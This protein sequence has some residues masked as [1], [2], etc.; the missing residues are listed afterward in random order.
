MAGCC[1]DE[2]EIAS[3]ALQKRQRRMLWAVLC[4]NA[5]MFAVEFGAGVLAGSTALLGDSL[6]MLGDAMVYALSL[7]VIAKSLRWKAMSA[8]IKGAVMLVFSVLVLL[9]AIHKAVAGAV[10]ASA[11]MMVIGSAALLANMAC[12]LLLTRHRED[13]VNM[14][15]AWV[16]SRNDLVANTGV[17]VAGIAVHVTQ[18]VWPDILV[19]GAI[20]V[21]F[22]QSSIGVLRDAWLRYRDSSR[23]GGFSDSNAGQSLR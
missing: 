21:L 3:R 1:C 11:L 10:P 17:I 12:L 14:R 2:N 20:A 6:D 15:S 16:C 7:V 8:G 9:E 5:T 22:F 18:S 13:D 19:G 4:V 23:A